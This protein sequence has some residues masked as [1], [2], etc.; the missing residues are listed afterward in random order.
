MKIAFFSSLKLD[1]SVFCVGPSDCFVERCYLSI[2]SL[3]TRDLILTSSFSL[4]T[5]CDTFFDF[6]EV[7]LDKICPVFN[8]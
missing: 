2:S 5:L 6:A 3:E 7:T 8:Q 1:L 4:V